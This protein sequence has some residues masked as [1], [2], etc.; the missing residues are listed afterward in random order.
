MPAFGHLRAARRVAVRLVVAARWCRSRAGRP[1][2]P[3]TSMNARPCA[4]AV[5]SLP[6]PACAMSCL[7]RFSI[8][9]RMPVPPASPMWLL[10]IDT[11]SMPASLSALM[12]PGWPR[13]RCRRRGSAGWSGA[14]FSKFAIARSA[15]LEVVA[16][17]A[18]LPVRAVYGQVPAERRAVLAG[19]VISADAAVEREVRCP[20]RL[21][22]RADAAVEQDV[23]ARDHRPRR[24]LASGVAP[25]GDGEAGAERPL[26]RVDVTGPRRTAHARPRRARGRQ[27]STS[28]PRRNA[29]RSRCFESSLADAVASLTVL[30]QSPSV[31]RS[32]SRAAR[33][34][35]ASL[36]TR[37]SALYGPVP[38][39]SRSHVREADLRLPGPEVRD[40]DDGDVG[41]LRRTEVAD[42]DGDGVAVVSVSDGEGE[43]VDGD[44]LA[45]LLGEGEPAAR[46][47]AEGAGARRRARAAVERVRAEGRDQH[48]R[49]AEDRRTDERGAA[50]WA[51]CGRRERRWMVRAHRHRAEGQSRKKNAPSGRADGA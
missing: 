24:G 35:S 2:R 8:V 13:R 19:P 50:T 12:L 22:A 26:R 17:R 28:P 47:V 46:R 33:I 30:S 5:M 38:C 18:R 44:P 49:P 11:Q 9:W 16:H 21:I 3:P 1:S 48:E 20:S 4:A 40:R 43:A 25:L 39:S 45:V 51:G 31:A 6:A 14:G 10:A 36:A 23:A 27:A 34:A 42:G 41:K 32:A 7:S 15:A 29:S 37:V